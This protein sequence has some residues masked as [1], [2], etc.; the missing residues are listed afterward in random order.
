MIT[1][2]ESITISYLKA[3]AIFCVVC[4]HIS[5]VPDSFSERSKY[6]CG[7][8]NEIGAI[9]VG[10]FFVISGYL[11]RRKAS[12]P[13]DIR[14]F[15][16]K[17]SRTLVIPWVIAAFLVYMYVAI[18]KGGTIIDGILSIMGYKSSYW[19][20]A[21]LMVLYFVFCFV[22]KSSNEIRWL[23]L[24]GCLSFLSVFLRYL[25][26]IDSTVI[27]VYLNV[28]NWCIFFAVGYWGAIK[29]EIVIKIIQKKWLSVLGASIALIMLFVPYSLKI[30][31]FS[32][33]CFWYIPV[34]L[35]ICISIIGIC[36][37]LSEKENNL[38]I[39]IGKLSYPIYLYHELVWAG[40]IVAVCNRFDSI[41]MLIIRPFIVIFFV[42]VELYLGKIVFGV[43]NKKE[44]YYNIIGA[45]LE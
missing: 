44:V 23:V 29:Y 16:A 43:V 41:I 27:G 12:T 8:I 17:K 40:L 9:G 37:R 5:S 24:S 34:E 6:I 31:K 28:F 33:F 30:G 4:A 26:I 22:R 42:C 35:I 2:R 39:F 1:K 20:L 15:F 21:V 7:I 3:V 14:N 36:F 25:G 38:L 18:R 10:I 32:Y 11:F 45:R 13:Y 19:Y